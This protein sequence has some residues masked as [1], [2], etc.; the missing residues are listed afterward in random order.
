MQNEKSI[1]IDSLTEVERQPN[2]YKPGFASMKL[3]NNLIKYGIWLVICLT[4]LFTGLGRYIG[5]L[6]YERGMDIMIVTWGIF[7]V[8]VYFVFNA[9]SFFV[10]WKLENKIAPEYG[11]HNMPPISVLGR[12]IRKTFIDG[13]GFFFISLFVI[14]CYYL[15]L[16]YIKGY[17]LDAS[18]SANW[19]IAAGLIS[20]LLI[21]VYFSIRRALST[22]LENS[23]KRVKIPTTSSSGTTVAIVF[24]IINTIL[25]IVMWWVFSSIRLLDKNYGLQTFCFII[26][27]IWAALFIMMLIGKLKSRE[28]QISVAYMIFVSVLTSWVFMQTMDFLSETPLFLPIRFV[29]FIIVAVLLTIMVIELI[30]IFQSKELASEKLSLVYS[31]SKRFSI[32]PLGVFTYSLTGDNAVETRLFGFFGLYY[33]FIPENLEDK[34]ELYASIAV[35]FARAKGGNGT[36]L[37]IVRSLLFTLSSIGFWFIFDYTY[38]A[39]G[40]SWFSGVTG[41]PILIFGILVIFGLVYGIIGTPLVYIINSIVDKSS[42]KLCDKI[43]DKATFDSYKSMEDRSLGVE[44]SQDKIANLYFGRNQQAL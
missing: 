12:W 14:T 32:I 5:D 34:Q 35:A 16:V 9:I 28:S 43:V 19:W 13:I 23:V 8:L 31:M 4:M 7:A 21:P 30:S 22:I 20:L 33:I 18:G 26:T 41:D 24:G 3:T 10:D 42:M 40:M 15:P 38:A 1:K 27:I 44:G 2:P 17:K 25:I 37:T 6:A 39:P 29:Y 11:I 36:V